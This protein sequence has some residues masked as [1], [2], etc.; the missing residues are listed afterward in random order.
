MI[1]PKDDTLPVT[2]FTASLD[3]Y[4]TLDSASSDMYHPDQVFN[5]Q[6]CHALLFGTDGQGQCIDIEKLSPKQYIVQRQESQSISRL[7]KKGD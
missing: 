7:S 2:G 1:L 6:L 4:S 5:S 3:K